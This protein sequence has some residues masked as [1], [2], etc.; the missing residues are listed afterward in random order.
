MEGN[1]GADSFAGLHDLHLIICSRLRE[2]MDSAKI[3]GAADSLFAAFMDL[4][5]HQY[6]QSFHAL[7]E[8]MEDA[9]SLTDE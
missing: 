7:I 1:K 8:A 5:M 6:N 9:E 2:R 3:K 4:E